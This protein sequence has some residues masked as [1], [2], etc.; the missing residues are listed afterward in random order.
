M[1]NLDELRRMDD[2]DEPEGIA[3]DFDELIASRT[4]K[5]SRPFLGMTPGQR[6]FL[7]VIVFL[8]VLILGTGLLFV[9]G[10]LAF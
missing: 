1:S 7:S 8:N 5:K 3:V 6:A 2:D 9:T 4:S 10:R